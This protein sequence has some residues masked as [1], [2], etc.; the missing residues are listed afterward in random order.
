M[1]APVGN[2]GLDSLLTEDQKSSLEKNRFNKENGFITFGL[3]TCAIASFVVSVTL[4][5]FVPLVVSVGF[6][7]APP[8]LFSLALLGFVALIV[9]IG[10]LIRESVV[11]DQLASSTYATKD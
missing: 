3:R 7:I 1:A 2:N 10:C 11:R 4:L 5:V 6:V 8:I 9:A